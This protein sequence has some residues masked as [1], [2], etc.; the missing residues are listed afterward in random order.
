MAPAAA[1]TTESIHP[2]LQLIPLYAMSIQKSLA[3]RGGTDVRIDDR[4]Y[5]HTLA[6]VNINN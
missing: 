6:H 3:L 1:A 4:A 2:T 5:Y